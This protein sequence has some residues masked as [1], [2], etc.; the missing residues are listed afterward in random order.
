VVRTPG[1]HL[2]LCSLNDLWQHSAVMGGSKPLYPTQ[3]LALAAMRIFR[4]SRPFCRTLAWLVKR[5]QALVE[6]NPPRNSQLETH[7]DDERGR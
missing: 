6:T 5:R 4:P 3:N 1:S 7:P 2:L